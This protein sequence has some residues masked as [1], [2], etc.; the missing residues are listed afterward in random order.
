MRDENGKP[1]NPPNGRPQYYVSVCPD[2]SK[3]FL[4]EHGKDGNLVELTMENAEIIRRLF[5]PTTTPTGQSRRQE[6][7]MAF[8]AD[9]YKRYGT[10]IQ[11]LYPSDKDADAGF[12]NFDAEK[13]EFLENL[14]D[15]IQQHFDDKMGTN[16]NEKKDD[17]R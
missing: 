14:W 6:D 4:V 1:T 8:L 11:P 5:L 17:V 9:E 3:Q 10:L 7:L 12:E 15:T 16:D 13:N 2:T